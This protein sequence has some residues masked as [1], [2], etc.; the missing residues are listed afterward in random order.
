MEPIKELH[1]YYEKYTTQE[2]R[3]NLTAFIMQQAYYMYR[4]FHNNLKGLDHLDSP[5]EMIYKACDLYDA[6]RKQFTVVGL[7]SARDT[8]AYYKKDKTVG[9]Y[10]IRPRPISVSLD[11]ESVVEKYSY[12]LNKAKENKDYESAKL[13]IGVV[14][15]YAAVDH[16]RIAYKEPCFTMTYSDWFI[17]K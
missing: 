16:L 10:A 15:P 17:T 13:Y 11:A 9:L 2:D 7:L 8:I 14:V 3:Y 4:L 1:P 6:L 12:L 5:T